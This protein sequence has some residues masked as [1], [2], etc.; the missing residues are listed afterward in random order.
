M[1]DSVRQI[2]LIS[3]SITLALLAV[4]RSAWSIVIVGRTI[5]LCSVATMNLRPS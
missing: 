5:P 2:R 4:S 3:W 1:L